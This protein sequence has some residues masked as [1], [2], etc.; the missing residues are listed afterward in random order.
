MASLTLD[1]AASV[2]QGWC[3]TP[4]PTTF[5]G[6]PD[7]SSSDE[8]M[9]TPPTNITSPEPDVLPNGERRAA[10]G[11]EQAHLA[12]P[13]LE[14]RKRPLVNMRRTPQPALTQSK[15]TSMFQTA[16]PTAHADNPPPP[17]PVPVINPP[18][19][20]R[21]M[22]TDQVE[23]EIGAPARASQPI[24]EDFLL[25]SLKLNTEHILKSFNNHIN[26]LAQRVDGNAA[27]IANNAADIASQVAVATDHGAKIA[28]LSARVDDLERSG[29]SRAT[30]V[31]RRATLS[32]DYL[33]ARR[34][35][36]LWPVSGVSDEDI[37]EAVGDFIHGTLRVPDSDVSQEDIENVARTPDR[38]SPGVSNEVLVTFC[39]SRKRDLVVSHSVNLASMVDSD[40]KPTAGVR[41]EIPTGL[42]DTFRLLSR[43]GTR[44]RA[45]HGVGTKRH[46]KFDDFHGSLFTNI[47]LPG[48]ESWT[49][50]TPEMARE[51][52]EA[53]IR[54]ESACTR[55][56]LATK[57]IPG[58]RDRLHGPATAPINV[59]LPPLGDNRAV[60]ALES[61]AIPPGK[62]P[63][64][65][66]PGR[67]VL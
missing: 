1:G 46:I 36:R 47:K 48:D 53:S 30:P 44:L 18:P 49:R 10:S 43:F 54:E 19:A 59:R 26:T 55:K 9:V 29:S 27:L 52:M 42:M 67:R 39:D 38:P 8:C 5:L 32:K 45:R 63:R 4:K 21:M 41:L 33:F 58:P 11:T 2:P 28:A 23:M 65:T 62:R 16:T 14:K 7:L 13:D 35:I 37:W 51:D 64:W 17:A 22:T 24:T 25:R 3:P 12:S 15:L 50:V 57:L 56:R 61:A 60:D 20:G 31:H 40:G 6:D 34:S 66:A